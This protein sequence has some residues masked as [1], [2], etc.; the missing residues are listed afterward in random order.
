MLHQRVLHASRRATFLKQK[1]VD[2]E[3]ELMKDV[4]G[5]EVDPPM[6]KTT[7]MPPMEIKGLGPMFPRV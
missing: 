2:R 6:Y 1:W 3:T 5:W 7:W 4:H